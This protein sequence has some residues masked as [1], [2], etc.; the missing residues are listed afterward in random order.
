M[1]L[2][3]RH[4]RKYVMP[5]KV[6]FASRIVEY[7]ALSILWDWSGQFEG[8]DIARVMPQFVI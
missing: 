6:E 7:L 4:Y 3:K 8:S 5:P 1:G 2:D